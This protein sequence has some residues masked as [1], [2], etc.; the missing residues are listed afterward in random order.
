ME[1]IEF[2]ASRAG[3][4]QQKC[5]EHLMLTVVSTLLAVLLGVPAG[6]LARRLHWL[7]ATVLFVSNVVQTVPSLAMLALLLPLLGIG[8]V[9]AMTALTLYALLPI[10]RNTLVGLQTIPPTVLEAADGLGFTRRQRLLWVELPLILP[11]LIAGVRTAAVIGVGI[12]TLSA[13]IGAGGLGDFI[14]RGLAL[15]NTRLVLLGAVPAALLAILIDQLFSLVEQALT[16]GRKP[17]TLRRRVVVYVSTLAILS[18]GWSVLPHLAASPAAPRALIRIG[19]KNFTEQLIIGEVIAQWLEQTT[20]LRVERRFNLG[21]T[22]ICHEALV[23]GDIDL[24][25]EY[26]GTGL[27]AILKLP[28]VSDPQQALT[29]VRDAYRQQFD[30]HWLQPLGFNN[31]YALAVRESDAQRNGWERISDLVA[32]APR[33]RAGFTPEFRE[34][35]DGYPGL[36]RAYGLEFGAV[37]DMDP[38]LMYRAVAQGAVDVISAFAT[39]GRILAYRLRVLHDDRRYFPPYQAVPVVR[40]EVLRRHPELRDAL[41][42]LANRIDD[43]AMQRLNYEVD[44]RGRLPHEV[45]REW[46][47]QFR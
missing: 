47:Q 43:A 37:R 35:P 30:L 16:P 3:E 27:T 21:G 4:L 41:E 45:A 15:N 25:V 9:P 11:V 38:S 28:P 1:W 22:I 24:Y 14:N 23:R 33:L 19:T 18:V 2:V 42:Q 44:E 40:G 39:D 8:V 20:D 12:A 26:T 13:F 32:S 46:L 29:R 36:V 10:V 31:T 5:G 34:R 7:R 6:I 17:A